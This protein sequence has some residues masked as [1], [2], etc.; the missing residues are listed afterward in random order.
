MDFIYIDNNL[1]ILEKILEIGEIIENNINIK[2]FD[3]K[4]LT[5]WNHKKKNKSSQLLIVEYE[6][7][8]KIQNTLLE[9]KIQ[10]F[11]NKYKYN[12]FDAQERNKINDKF[13]LA[14]P[15]FRSN[16]F[17]REILLKII[18]HISYVIY[19][20]SSIISA[21]NSNF[22]FPI[23]LKSYRIVF[24]VKTQ[25]SF[26]NKTYALLYNLLNTCYTKEISCFIDLDEKEQT[27][28]TIKYYTKF[29][30]KRNKIFRKTYHRI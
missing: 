5:K 14:N 20:V 9:N 15:Y 21:K 1:E 13:F 27:S 11:L 7:I 28:I 17:N 25:E 23:I 30:K 4:D 22:D 19:K 2:S 18:S 29:L 12:L 24:N 16:K 6:N 8:N 26:V 10:N 3:D